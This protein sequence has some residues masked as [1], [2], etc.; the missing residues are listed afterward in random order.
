MLYKKLIILGEKINLF[1]GPQFTNIRT[2][3][4]SLIDKINSL[5]QFLE[6]IQ[7]KIEQQQKK[8]QQ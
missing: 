7:A 3:Y 2:G 6:G 5:K 8:N 1:T 4:I